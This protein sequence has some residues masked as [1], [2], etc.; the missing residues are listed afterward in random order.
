MKFPSHIIFLNGLL[1][2]AAVLLLS[3][4]AANGTSGG[5]RAAEPEAVV[6]IEPWDG[7]GMEIPLDGSS[8]EAWE[9]SLARV[10]AHT[11]ASKY[12]TLE[13]AIQYHLMYDLKSYRDMEKLIKRLD[14]KTGYEI[15]A[16]VKWRK[17]APGKGQVEKGSADAKIIDS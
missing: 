16:L 17:P 7:D 6:E 15:V 12:Q 9:T 2:L 14:G 10:E 5:S 4:C 1:A 13:N 8:M 3:A 11:T